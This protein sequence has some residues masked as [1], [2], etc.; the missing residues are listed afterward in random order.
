[1]KTRCPGGSNFWLEVSEPLE[2]LVKYFVMSFRDQNKLSTEIFKTLH[3]FL[4]AYV[5]RLFDNFKEYIIFIEVLS[6]SHISL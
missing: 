6:K 3:N 1:M 4:F 2:E 5:F